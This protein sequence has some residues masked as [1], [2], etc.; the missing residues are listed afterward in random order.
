[1]LIIFV[2]VVAVRLLLDA[3]APDLP[4]FAGTGVAVL[5]AVGVMT[6]DERRMR[7]HG[8]TVTED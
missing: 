3:V 2:T 6:L 4:W 8:R 1:M 5:V 7:R